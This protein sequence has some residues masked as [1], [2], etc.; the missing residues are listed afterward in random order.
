MRRV[1]WIQLAV[2]AWCAFE[3]RALPVEWIKHTAYERFGWIALAVWLVPLAWRP[4]SRDQRPVAMW[5]SYVAIA[6]AFIGRVGDNNAVLYLG[7]AFAATALLPTGWRWAVWL[8][9]ATSW[10]TVFGYLLKDQATAV[11][12][13]LRIVTAAVGAA[14]VL[15]PCP[16]PNP[17]TVEAA[18]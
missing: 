10:M 3:C 16:A 4:W 9:C 11:V 2:L 1:P 15:L 18:T 8:A 13:T 17:R 7:A 14:I 6:L 12:A 5:P